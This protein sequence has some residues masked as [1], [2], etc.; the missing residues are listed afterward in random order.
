MSKKAL[1]PTT[2]LYPMP[3]LLLAVRTEGKGASVMTVAWAGIVGGQPPM[4]A[5]EV[6]AR[7]H[8]TPFLERERSFTLNVPSASM[9]VGVDYCGTV[10]GSRDPDKAVTCGWTLLPST[11]ITAPMIAECPLSLECRVL[12]RVEAGTGFFYLAEVLETHADV[13]VLDARGNVSAGLLNP[14]VFTPDGFYYA[15]GENLGKAWSIGRGLAR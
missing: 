2:Q 3:A 14:L 8:T 10:S 7:H 12:K 1:G 15:L 9:A 5:L 11:H 6:G 4:V 13:S